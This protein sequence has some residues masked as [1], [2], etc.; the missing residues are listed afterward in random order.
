MIKETSI[1]IAINVREA[2][3]LLM[4]LRQADKNDFR[5]RGEQPIESGSI[6]DCK[7]IKL[8]LEKLLLMRDSC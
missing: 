8:E 7:N 2:Q 6:K 3:S 5:W 4:F 1:K